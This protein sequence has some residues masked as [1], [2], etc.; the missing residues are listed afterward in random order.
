MPTV[1]ATSKLQFLKIAY[2]VETK[3]TNEMFST[4]FMHLRT[5]Y[6]CGFNIYNVRISTA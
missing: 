3:Y 2:L 6:E 1:F 4:V 5:I